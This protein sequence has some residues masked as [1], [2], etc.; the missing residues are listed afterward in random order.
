MTND[1]ADERIRKRYHHLQ[2]HSLGT[3]PASNQSQLD[4]VF[5]WTGSNVWFP[6]GRFFPQTGELDADSSGC[7]AV[8]HA[9]ADV[10]KL[11]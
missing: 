11:C 1:V 2:T 10:V 6:Y 8:V 7:G 5:G 9:E 3:F 4:C